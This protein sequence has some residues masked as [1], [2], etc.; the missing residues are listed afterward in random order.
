M[1]VKFR[2]SAV[3]KLMVGGESITEAQLARLKELDTRK[4]DAEAKPLTAKMQQELE[5]LIQKR[6]AEFKFGATAM[7]FIR[8]C[9]LRNQYGYEEPLVTS[10]MLKGILCEDQAIGILDRQIPV[11]GAFRYKNSDQ[12]EDEHFTGSPD[13]VLNEDWIEDI[14]CSWT[15]RTFIETQKPDPLYYAQGQVYMALTG[16]KY[17]RL[18]HVLLETPQE[19]VDE[20]RKRFY[21]RFNGDEQNPHYIR[22]VEAVENMHYACRNVPESNRVKTFVINRNDQFIGT[23]RSRVEIARKVYSLMTLG[24]NNE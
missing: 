13:I 21:F 19:L 8:D 12:F 22:A 17:F 15:L 2:A 6:D 16:R 1:A 5:E 11:E 24:D 20:E 10:E 18:A 7:G 23:L 4:Y 3:G 14:K 9:W